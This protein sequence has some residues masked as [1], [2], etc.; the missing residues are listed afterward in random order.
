MTKSQS[1]SYF[2][3]QFFFND[4]FVCASASLYNRQREGESLTCFSGTLNNK[5]TLGSYVIII[6][7]P[8][9]EVSPRINLRENITFLNYFFNIHSFC[10]EFITFVIELIF[11]MNSYE[12]YH[13]S[14]SHIFLIGQRRFLPKFHDNLLTPLP[15]RRLYL[16][17]P[18]IKPHTTFHPSTAHSNQRA[19]SCVRD[20]DVVWQIIQ[21]KLLPN[22]NLAQ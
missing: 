8:R 2:G 19:S 13:F 11:I 14:H 15:F 7:T 22:G 21:P 12:N 18:T 5:R 6:Y 3:N 9:Q 4:Y 20:W 1:E 16:I 10:R 17:S